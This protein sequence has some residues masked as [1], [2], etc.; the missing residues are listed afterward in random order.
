MSFQRGGMVAKLA[1]RTIELN[2][3]Q[4]IDTSVRIQLKV[5]PESIVTNPY[6]LSNLRMGEIVAF[7]PQCLHSALYQRHRVAV[8]LVT[9]NRDD[10]R[11]ELQTYGHGQPPGCCARI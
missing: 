5:V 7:Q 6:Q 11:C 3:F 2:C 9:E 1:L 8:P 10:F 4:S